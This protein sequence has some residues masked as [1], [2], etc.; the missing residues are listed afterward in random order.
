MDRNEHGV[1][2]ARYDSLEVKAETQESIRM[3]FTRSL[4]TPGP[5]T[6]IPACPMALALTF[7]AIYW[8]TPGNEEAQIRVLRNFNLNDSFTGS[9]L[10]DLPF[11]KG[12]AF[13]ANWSGPVIPIFGNLGNG[14]H[15]PSHIGLPTFR[16][17][18]CQ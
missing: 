5:A 4:A 11:G 1:C 16:S 14:F 2:S 9:L 13:G 12:K 18:Q 10:Y 15:H 3:A 6:S 17:R 8:P 7:G